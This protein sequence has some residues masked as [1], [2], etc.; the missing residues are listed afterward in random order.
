MVGDQHEEVSIPAAAA[1][2]VEIGRK[3][4]PVEDLDPIG[5]AAFQGIKSLNRIQ[6]VVF[7]TAY[8]YDKITD[9]QTVYIFFF[10]GTRGKRFFAL[11]LGM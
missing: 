10:F 6:S 3:L 11:G 4:K 5:Q 1:A 8:R 2:P 7:D 9:R